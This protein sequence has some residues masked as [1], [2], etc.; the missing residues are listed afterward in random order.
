MVEALVAGSSKERR[1]YWRWSAEL[2]RAGPV[3]GRGVAEGGHQ[4][5][6]GKVGL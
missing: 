2:K 1:R 3:P 5:F 6:F 4:R